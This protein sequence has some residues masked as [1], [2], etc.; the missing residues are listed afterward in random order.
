M[1]A[2]LPL[3]DPLIPLTS[4]LLPHFSLFTDYI[5]ILRSMVLADDM[6]EMAE[7]A[8]LANGGERHNRKTGR[9]VRTVTG[10]LKGKEEGGYVR[11][12]KEAGKEGEAVVRDIRLGGD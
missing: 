12:L 4:N 9:P 7:E 1:R 2:L 10:W 11:Y 3:L 6:M 8:A 5:P